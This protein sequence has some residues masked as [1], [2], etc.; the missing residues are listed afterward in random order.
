MKTQISRDSFQPDKRYSGIYQQQGRMLTDADWNEQVGISREQLLQALLDVIGNGAPRIGAVAIRKD[1]KIQPGVLYVD[2]IRAEMPGLLPLG[3]NEQPDLDEYPEFPATGSYTVYADIWER[4]VT[5]LEDSRLRDEGLHGADTCTRTETML[6]IKVCPFLFSPA[7]PKCGDA[8]LSLAL[9]SNLETRDSCDP[10]AG[11]ISVGKG[12]V[13]SYLFRLEVHDVEGDNPTSPT[14]L[15]FKWSSE[16]GAEQYEFKHDSSR[17]DA[18]PVDA[19]PPG[20][21]TGDFA[22]EFYDLITEKQLGFFW[23]GALP[24][25]PI[26][27]QPKRGR[28]KTSDQIA[29]QPAGGFVRRWDGW[30]KLSKSASGWVLTGWDQGTQL[31]GTVLSSDPLALNL[32]ALKLNLELENRSFLAGDFW[33]AEVREAVNKPGESI[34]SSVP[35]QGIAHHYLTLAHVNSG[36]VVGLQGVNQ[37]QHKFPP[38]TDLRASD[39]GYET[40]C[41]SGLFDPSHD[42]IEKALNRVCQL[43]AEHIGYR[44][45]CTRGLFKDFN[46]TMKEALDKVCQIDAGD[47]ALSQP[48]KT[49]LYGGESVQTVE[50]ALGLLCNIQAGQISYRAAKTCNF[51]GQLSSDTVQEAIDALCA[52]PGGCRLTVGNGGIFSSLDEAIETILNSKD[53]GIR[54]QKDIPNEKEFCLCL[55]PGRH[56]FAGHEIE[57]LLPDSHLSLSGCGSSTRLRIHKGRM[58]FRRFATVSISDMDITACD[59]YT[60]ALAFDR[61]EEVHLSGVLVC[62]LL[63]E[64]T[65]DPRSLIFVGGAQNVKIESAMLEAARPKSLDTVRHIFED[66]NAGLGRLCANPNRQAF[67]ESVVEISHELAS[68]DGPTRTKLA[69]EIEKKVSLKDMSQREDQSYLALVKALR[70][71]SEQVGDLIGLL[72]RIRREAIRVRPGVA[73]VINDVS[74]IVSLYGPSPHGPLGQLMDVLSP[75]VKDT[76]VNF[77]GTGSAFRMTGCHVSRMD[78][79]RR[80]VERLKAIDPKERDLDDLFEAALLTDSVVALGHSQLVFVNTNLSSNQ[81]ELKVPRDKGDIDVATVISNSSIYVG[82]RGDKGT[83]IINV[84][85][86]G[87]SQQAANLGVRI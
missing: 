22:Y 87:R 61:C 5:A 60:G 27:F 2:G 66:L 67:E 77:S 29:I 74:G 13:G 63:P 50:Q 80:L 34:A 16:N 15:T 8:L 84:V 40:T 19:L 11:L 30:C 85:P 37:R 57:A 86:Q 71:D 43:Q 73:L 49:G 36:E 28:L 59:N 70:S 18:V 83:T 12:R 17:D 23:G 33:L 39:V 1:H 52:R 65:G 47:V 38:L 69:D 44:G 31:S 58:M 55:L 54:K 10:C 35:P 82:N 53:K 62:G 21:V 3:A 51:L 72:R 75:L 78:V 6:Q 56:E 26:N 14:S 41:G 64:S 46:G 48:C 25:F 24:G 42:T 76:Q 4:V 81:F 68:T 20:F 32:R 79:S 7:F 45:D 9:Q